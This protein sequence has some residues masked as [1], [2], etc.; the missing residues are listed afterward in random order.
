MGDA[1]R[2][3]PPQGPTPAALLPMSPRSE[4]A[5]AIVVA[6]PDDE[7]LW[8]G[9]A[10]LLH[11]EWRCS[12]FSLCRGDD[13][14]RAPRFARAVRALG[15]VD[16]RMGA[17]D[18]SPEQLPLSIAAVAEAILAL[19]PGRGVVPS[20]SGA[21]PGAV[22]PAG[23]AASG[24]SPCVRSIAPPAFDLLLTHSPHGEYTRH[25]RHEEVS[26]AVIALMRAGR[27]VSRELWLF[28]YED[29][30]R[31]RYPHAIPYAPLQLL[32]S[33]EIWLRKHEIITE[34]YDFS[35]ESWEARATPRTE[36]F[37]RF[38]EATTAALAFDVEGDQA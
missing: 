36:A 7:T 37:W 11:P 8:S 13:R 18:D 31:R 19:E 3:R 23:A 10:I 21:I 5:V 16:W 26:R 6:H 22:K 29:E 28:A 2:P 15:A 25:L 35:P 38:D 32:L 34:L 14:D 12:I 20:A 17:L 1:V 30:E 27:L 24:G 4:P 9:G 33:E